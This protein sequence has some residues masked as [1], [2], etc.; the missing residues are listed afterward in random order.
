M[1][2]RMSQ[3][4]DI[5]IIGGGII[6][7]AGACDLARRG[8]KVTLI[9]KGQIGHGCSYGNAGF[10]TPCFALPLPMP[11]MLLKSIRW[12]LDPEGPLYIKPRPSWEFLCW[13]ACFARSMNQRKLHDST[14]ALTALATYSLDA[15]RRIDAD[16]PGCIG[17]AQRGLIT[18]AATAAGADDARAAMGLVAPHGIKGQ[19]LS[20]DELRRLEPSVTGEIAG[21]VFFPDEAH[22]EPLA[23]VQTMA[24]LAAKAGAQILPETEM[25]EFVIKG[26]RIEGVRTTRGLIRADQFVLATGSWS[27]SIAKLLRLRVPILA[28]KGYAVVVEPFA[29]APTRP[30]LLLENKIGVTPRQNSV[31]LAGTLELVDRDESITPRRVAAMLSGGRRFLNLPE[32]PRIIE[33]WRG[34][35]PCTPDGVPII[36]RPARFDN[37][38]LAAGH[39]M[40]GLLSAPGTARLVGDLITGSPSHFDPHP[41]RATRF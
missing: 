22:V 40:I 29:P 20:P 12:M 15:Y 5:L 4:P 35:R 18:I 25:F 9:D 7:A 3:T 28:G 6:G 37:L 19:V 10:V 39:Q 23:A 26:R 30:L 8:A 27:P 17:F 33:V 14:R 24:R 2:P 21:G 36:G 1:K 16:E 34:L 41:F 31:R 11:G 38:L 13:L 32:E